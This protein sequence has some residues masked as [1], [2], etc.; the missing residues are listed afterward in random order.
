MGDKS[1]V[2]ITIAGDPA[3]FKKAA[4]DVKKIFGQIEDD[5][6]KTSSVLDNAFSSFLGNLAANVATGAFNLLKDGF[7]T[8]IQSIGDFSKE[9]QEGEAASLKLNLALAQTG[10]FSET[11][12]QSMDDFANTLKAT[13][14]IEDEAIKKNAALIQSYGNL[15]EQGLKRAT[16]AAADLSAAIGVD[17][18]TASAILG[19]A[20]QG[21]VEAL[22]KYG[23]QVEDT[24]DKTR[25][26]QTALAQ[27]EQRFGGS[28]A[29][30]NDNLAGAQNRAKQ[31]FDDIGKAIGE[32]INETPGLKG[33]FQGVADVF[34]TVKKLI[35]EN[36]DAIKSLVANGIDIFISSIGIAGDSAQF[37]LD[38]LSVGNIVINELEN[39]ILKI[40]N[41]IAVFVGG[42]TATTSV[43]AD[44]FGFTT[45][46]IDGVTKSISDFTDALREVKEE[47]DADSEAFVA[48]NEKRK[49]SIESFTTTAM[50]QIQARVDAERAAGTGEDEAFLQR[51]SD[52]KALTE[53]ASADELAA[54]ALFN[55]QLLALVTDTLGKTE[56]AEFAAQTKKLLNEGKYQEALKK[57]RAE[58]TKAEENQI[59]SVQKYEE[60][61][62]K[63]RL[64]NTKSTFGA[65]STLQNS[66]SKELFAIGK[67]AAIGTAT[68]DGIAAVQKALASA[69]P[70]FNFA[71]AA[72]V[73]V[74][75]AANIGKIAS[76]SAPTGAFDG[77]L[78]TGGSG[79]KDDQPFMLSKGELVAPANSFD[80]VV[81]GTARARGFTQGDENSETNALLRELIEKQ[82]NSNGIVV[83]GDFLADEIYINRLVDK[84]R[85]AVL[86]RSADLGVN[87]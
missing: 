68:I 80:D 9:A 74:A 4:E 26:F 23:L 54:R 84:I 81:E 49:A 33:A 21:N 14:G 78:V 35:V 2:V 58:Q 77:A 47:N 8:A 10:K 32:A 42:L 5:G 59:F 69:P 27:I 50:E 87:G 65:L 43:I 70:P 57:I 20:A 73:G 7:A 66:S 31:G 40:A 11:T 67:A 19:K 38:A 1:G 34:D 6:K 18:D 56:A 63:Q 75:T 13:T 85:E 79:Y 12:A 30:L 52:K 28:A 25:D 15:D 46:S 55:D 24:G 61:T 48:A 45:E 29:V 3:D 39:T 51:M 64:E 41:A 71:L 76:Q 36:E 83:Q 72:L 62:Q 82:S 44:F 22:K 53:Q 86:F 60:L 37:F 16:T 17:F